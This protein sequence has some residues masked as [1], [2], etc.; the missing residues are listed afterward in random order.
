[1]KKLLIGILVLSSLAVSASDLLEK[2]APVAEETVKAEAGEGYDADGFS[3]NDCQLAP[4]NAVVICEVSASKGD[5]EAIDTYRAVLN[6]SCT[7]VFRVDLISE[8]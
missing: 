3:A 8:E 4:N 5:G 6:K 7:K 2:C 1:M